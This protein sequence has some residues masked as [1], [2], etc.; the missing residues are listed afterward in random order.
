MHLTTIKMK[1]QITHS[2]DY[3]GVSS[4]SL[5]LIHCLLFQLVTF[6]PIGITHNHYVDLIFALIGLFAVVKILK[7]NTE[8]YIKLILSISMTVI[9]GCVLVT[10]FF[11]YHSLLL[12]FGGV[13]MIVGHLLNFKNHKH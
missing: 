8:L 4:A 2:L 13:G 9:I 1:K 7:T 3:I 5:C 10:I 12:Y 11:H 6:I